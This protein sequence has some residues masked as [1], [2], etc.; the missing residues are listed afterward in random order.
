MKK[1]ILTTIIA[2]VTVA[3]A[4]AQETANVAVTATVQDALSLTP[5]AV[6]FGAIQASQ[7]SYIKANSNDGTAETNLGNGATAGSLQIEGTTGV[8]VTVSWANG[9]LTDGSG[10]NPTTFT[11][12]VYNDAAAVTSGN[13]VTLTGGNITLDVGGQLAA[14]TN[15]GTYSTGNTNGTPVVFT[16]QYASI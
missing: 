4:F 9:T 1:V 2:L 15:P 13:D 8:D 16:V 10:L 3:G 6:A 7:V 5:T 12:T 14:I 11:P